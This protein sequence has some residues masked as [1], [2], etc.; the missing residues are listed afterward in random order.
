MENKSVPFFVFASC[1][2]LFASFSFTGC[3]YQ[4]AGRGAHIPEGVRTLAIPVFE[5]KTLEPI[6]EEE[7]TP[8]VI[9]EFLRDSRIE[10]VNRPQAGLVLRGSVTSYKESPLSF[11]KDQNVLEYRI[12]VVTHLI[13]VRQERDAAPTGILWERDVTES[14]EY[15]AS[16]DVM[17]TRVAKLLALREIARNL[18]QNVADRVLQ[19]W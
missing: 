1:F 18:A 2:L 14:A 15:R 16:S 5:N 17:S 19:G 4:I 11:D 3:G 12:I 10:V 8:A 13:L 9:R 7:L 6:V